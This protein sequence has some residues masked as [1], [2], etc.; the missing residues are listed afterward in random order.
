VIN[1]NPFAELHRHYGPRTTP[2]V[3]ALVLL[4]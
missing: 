2:I 3:R 4:C 1:T